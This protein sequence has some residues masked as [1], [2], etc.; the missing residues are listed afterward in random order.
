MSD[1]EVKIEHP[2]FGMIS[3]SRVHGKTDLFAVDYPQG[4]FISLTIS[5]GRMYRR[6]GTEYFH[7][8]KEVIEV[9]MSE[10]QYAQMIASPNTSGVPCTISRCREGE[11]KQ[12]PP[13]PKHMAD[14]ASVKEEF[15]ERG[16]VIAAKYDEAERIINEML[17]PGQTPSKAKL[18]QAFNALTSAK[19]DLSSNMP[20]YVQQLQEETTRA[21]SAG[22]AEVEAYAQHVMLELASEALG[23]RI[24]NGEVPIRL[25]PMDQGQI[26]DQKKED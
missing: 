16:R 15:A 25:A 7:A 10:V 12:M 11:Y 2:S 5:T 3:V 1:E 8:D 13:P 20:F 21:T 24:R 6:Y 23:E 9:Y 26:E 14:A 18:S 17:Q 22:K 19:Q 4:H